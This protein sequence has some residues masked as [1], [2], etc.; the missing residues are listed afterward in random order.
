MGKKYQRCP[1]CG[2]NGTH[3]PTCSWSPPAAEREQF[4]RDNAVSLIQ[5]L[6]EK[7]HRQAGKLTEQEATILQLR[8]LVCRM[9]ESGLFEKHGGV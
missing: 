7:V 9:V 8:K 3:K 4:I 2:F 1:E 5:S 6:E